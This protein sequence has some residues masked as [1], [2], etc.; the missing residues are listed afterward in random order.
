MAVRFYDKHIFHDATFSDF[1]KDGPLIIVNASGLGNGVRFSFIQEYFNFICSDINSFSVSKAVTT[2]SSVPVLFL[3][4]VLE[5]FPECSFTEPEWLKTVKLN[6]KETEDPLLNE[7]IRGLDILANKEELKYIHLVDGG[8]TDNLG[9]HALYDLITVRGG[10]KEALQG[11]DKKP[12]KYFVIIS[13]N[14][15]TNPIREMD[16]SNEEPSISETVDAMSSAQ[17]HR[18]NSTTTAL[19]ESSI[20]KWAQEISTPDHQVKSYFINIALED[21]SNPEMRLFFNKILTS[22]GLSE[23][24]VNRLVNG[25]IELLHKNAEYQRLVSGLKGSIDTQK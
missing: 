7:T 15:S 22:F 10:A 13:V 11:L 3:P 16:V 1:K 25:G 8:I 5:K 14:S 4:V 9:L 17:L 24:T 6:A 19:M 12:P 21:H 2:S 18:Y 20:K 23:E